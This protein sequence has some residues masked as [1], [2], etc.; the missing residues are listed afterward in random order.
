MDA[1]ARTYRYLDAAEVEG[2]R[3]ARAAAQ[4]GAKK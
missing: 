3:K 1:T 4:Q 2:Q